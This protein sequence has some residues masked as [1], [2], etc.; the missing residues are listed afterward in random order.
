LLQQ[1]SEFYQQFLGVDRS[2]SLYYSLGAL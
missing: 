1:L 2:H